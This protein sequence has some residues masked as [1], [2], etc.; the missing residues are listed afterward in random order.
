VRPLFVRIIGISA[1][2]SCLP[3]LYRAY[4]EFARPLPAWVLLSTGETWIDHSLVGAMVAVVAAAWI[5]YELRAASRR[6][7]GIAT[8]TWRIRNHPELRVVLYT[9]AVTNFIR[10]PADLVQLV[11]LMRQSQNRLFGQ[12][13]WS[14]FPFDVFLYALLGIAAILFDRRLAKSE[15]QQSRTENGLCT[16]CG[17]D[18][19]ATPD[20]CPECG[21][22]PKK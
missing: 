13:Y 4:Q 11:F 5:N 18:L 22:A 6:R 21:V 16:T 20:R 7:R 17:Y 1:A 8:G 15:A 14:V 9:F 10:L 12:K 3:I 2:L 19:R